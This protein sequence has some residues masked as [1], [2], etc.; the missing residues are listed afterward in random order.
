MV[1]TG[2]ETK[3]GARPYCLGC[4][5][6]VLGSQCSECGTEVGSDASRVFW[7]YSPPRAMD[8]LELKSPG[9]LMLCIVIVMGI[10]TFVSFSS[11]GS[12]AVRLWTMAAWA[13]I[14]AAY[15]W[16]WLTWRSLRRRH[17]PRARMAYKTR[18]AWLLPLAVSILI[19]AAT[20]ARAPDYIRFA[21]SNRQLA[22]AWS[23]VQ[24]NGPAAVRP[25]P[26]WIGLYR[27][28]AIEVD[29]D[30]VRFITGRDGWGEGRGIGHCSG[31]INDYPASYAALGRGWFIF[32]RFH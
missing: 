7:G 20:V 30:C 19:W 16:R 31:D 9:Y 22:S 14:G 23:E 18:L 13:V 17:Q 1:W 6:P 11:P 26:R 5:Y 28:E 29:G 32:V 4:G 3:D 21:A 2:E 12:I 8:R 25:L 24:R 15:A 10:I 27:V